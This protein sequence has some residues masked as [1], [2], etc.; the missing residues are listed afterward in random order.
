[1]RRLHADIAPDDDRAFLALAI[2]LEAPAAQ[3]RVAEYGG[4]GARDGLPRGRTRDGR[5]AHPLRLTCAE[6]I[7]GKW[8]AADGCDGER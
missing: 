4:R 7:N 3:L 2:A 6:V 5:V 1:M 8:R